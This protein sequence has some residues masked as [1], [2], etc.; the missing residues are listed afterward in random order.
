LN[1]K[2]PLE[3]ALLSAQ[4]FYLLNLHSDAGIEV[5]FVLSTDDAYICYHMLVN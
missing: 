5:D 4:N 1:T 3:N 2:L